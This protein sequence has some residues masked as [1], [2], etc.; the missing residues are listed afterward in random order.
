MDETWKTTQNDQH[1]HYAEDNH[2]LL[3]YPAPEDNIRKTR[4][5]EKTQQPSEVG[6]V[7]L[8]K[9][10]TLVIT[11]LQQAQV[12]GKVAQQKRET[13]KVDTLNMKDIQSDEKNKEEHP[14]EIQGHQEQG[15]IQRQKR[16][17]PIL[18]PVSTFLYNLCCFK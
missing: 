6:K 17:A 4:E 7:T 14:K 18:Q 10:D 11:R 8:E 1:K 9:D 15:K 13:E 3:P 5:A 12:D 16:Q 2:P